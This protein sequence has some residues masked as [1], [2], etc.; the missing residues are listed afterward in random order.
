MAKETDMSTK[1][2]PQAVESG[3]YQEWLD[4]GLFKPNGDKKAHNIQS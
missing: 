4:Q 2:D 3:R 1:Y